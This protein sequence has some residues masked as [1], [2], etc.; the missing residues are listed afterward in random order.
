MAILRVL[1]IED[2]GGITAAVT[3]VLEVDGD[4]VPSHPTES[5]A[6]SAC[7]R[8]FHPISCWLI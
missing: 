7:G 4:E 5:P 3:F 8:R 1:V 6:A 2:D